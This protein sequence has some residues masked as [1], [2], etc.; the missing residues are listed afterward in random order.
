MPRLR[1]ILPTLLLLAVLPVWAAS[2]LF[3]NLASNAFETADNYREPGKW[4]VVMIWASDC[5]VCRREM[6]SYQQFHEQHR[7]QDARVLGITL[8]GLQ[9]MEDAREFI[10][11]HGVDFNNL[12]GEAEAVTAY[13]RVLTGSPWIGTPSF[14]IYGPDGTLM[15][16]QAGAV[17]VDLIEQFIATNSAAQ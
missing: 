12:I 17:P 7:Q 10:A 3:Q 9:G 2:P 6:G 13:Y 5:E 4:L 8:D 1:G 11:E 16:K 15:A 14:L